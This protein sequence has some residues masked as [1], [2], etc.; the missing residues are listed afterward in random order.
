[1]Y[2]GL[3]HFFNSCFCSGI[4]KNKK[5]C[6]CTTGIKTLIHQL[7]IDSQCV[8]FTSHKIHICCGMFI[9]WR[10]L[11]QGHYHLI[12]QIGHYCVNRYTISNYY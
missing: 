5:I 11:L 4:D 2:V 3:K 10:K 9:L 8:Y 7:I 12:L 6:V 1:M